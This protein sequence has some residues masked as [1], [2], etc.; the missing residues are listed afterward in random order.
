MMT[1]SKWKYASNVHSYV[2]LLRYTYVNITL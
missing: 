1:G 2:N